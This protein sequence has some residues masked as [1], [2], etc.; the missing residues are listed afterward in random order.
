M[1]DEAKAVAVTEELLV[2]GNDD[3][4]EGIGKRE[5]VNANLPDV[6]SFALTDRQDGDVPHLI[7]VDIRKT[8][9]NVTNLPGPFADTEIT[10]PRD[11]LFAILASDA[12]D[13]RAD[14]HPSPIYYHFSYRFLAT[15]EPS[16]LA[17]QEHA[18]QPRN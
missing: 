13:V 1:G 16:G 3:V 7:V 10:H 9:A 6:V 17:T 8:E 11:H 4:P 15:S 5:E 12:G 14:R 2:D 18:L